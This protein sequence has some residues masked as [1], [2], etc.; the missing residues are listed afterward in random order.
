VSGAVP[1]F[2]L[3]RTAARAAS[4]VLNGRSFVPGAA[5]LPAG[6]T[7]KSP[8][9]PLEPLELL[10]LVD[11]LE[12][13]EPLLL[14]LLEPPELPVAPELLEPLE[15]PEPLPPAGDPGDRLTDPPHPA[16]TR[17]AT[18]TATGFAR[19]VRIGM[20]VADLRVIAR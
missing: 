15:D 1:R 5:S 2:A 10:E 19:E 18:A 7:K 14:E 13:L 6:E 17:S 3:D 20:R 12:L 16:A 8:V 4:S 11:P 9:A